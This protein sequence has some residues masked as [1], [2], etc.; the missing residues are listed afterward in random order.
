M[1]KGELVKIVVAFL[2][3]AFSF[4]LVGQLAHRMVNVNSAL[5]VF[6]CLAIV[7]GVVGG[8]RH[9]WPTAFTS[10]LWA[11]VLF[12]AVLASPGQTFTI[13]LL[14][15]SAVAIGLAMILLKL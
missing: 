13:V 4:L 12:M 11:I 1:K 15:S 3:V 2:L 10:S 7:L 5:F 14:V 9:K 8:Y 6:L